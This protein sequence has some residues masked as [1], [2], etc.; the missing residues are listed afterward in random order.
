VFFQRAARC[1]TSPAFATDPGSHADGEHPGEPT[2]I[3]HCRHLHPRKNGSGRLTDSTRSRFARDYLLPRS[4]RPAPGTPENRGRDYVRR[5]RRRRRV[6][7]APA[8]GVRRLGLDQPPPPRGS[9]PPPQ[10]EVASPHHWSRSLGWACFQA[11]P[12][13]S[14]THGGPRRRHDLPADVARLAS[15]ER[16]APAL[17]RARSQPGIMGVDRSHLCRCPWA[18]SSRRIPQVACTRTRRRLPPLSA[19]A[20]LRT[21]PSTVP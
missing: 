18:P 13:R 14:T 10:A 2:S 15:L 5:R 20:R 11:T 7:G 3:R 6:A 17:D 19:R 8:S 4:G 21:N 16:R 12:S 9:A 1:S